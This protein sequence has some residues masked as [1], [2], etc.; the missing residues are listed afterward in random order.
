MWK[1]IA[2]IIA[3]LLALVG[4]ALAGFSF[5]R[6]KVL[7]TPIRKPLKALPE[8]YGLAPEQVRI[9]GPR[10]ALVGWYLPARNG[11]TLL[12]CHGINDNAGQWFEPVAELHT[13]SG[14]G[15]IMFDFAGHGRSDDAQVTY[16]GGEQLDVHAVLAYLRERG[17][18]DMSRL[19]LMGYSLGAITSVLYAAR[20]PIFRTVVIES[21]FADIQ[22]DIAHLFTRYTGLPSFPFANL[23]LFWAERLSGY[24]LSALRPMR[25]IGRISPGAVLIISDLEDTLAFE[26]YDGERLYSGA[27]EPKALWQVPATEHVQAFVTARAEWIEHVGGFLDRFLAHN[28]HPAESGPR[29]NP[30]D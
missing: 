19:G 15:A 5:V 1:R 16:G 24:K 2:G 17:D 4:A 26:P 9:P 28:P 3:G 14:Y 8:D 13:R 12:C 21:G 11:C 10:G 29:A 7:L 27:G 23:I 18:V 6:A 22:R 25:V 20:H 30:Q